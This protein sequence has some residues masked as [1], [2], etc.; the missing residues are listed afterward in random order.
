MMVLEK[1]GLIYQPHTSAGRVPTEAGYRAFVD[2]LTDLRPLPAPQIRA[3]EEFLA[4]ATDFEEVIARTVRLL[5]QLTRGAAVA[6][7]PLLPAPLLRRVEVVGLGPNRLV[8]VVITEGGQVFE[9]RLETREGTAEEALTEIRERLNLRLEGLSAERIRVET[10]NLIAEFRPENRNLAMQV[11]AAVA[12]MLRSPSQSRMVVAG[13][14]NI[15]RFGA[16][17]ADVSAVL[18][19][20]EQQ[21]ALLRLFSEAHPDRVRVSIGAENL[22]EDL[23]ETSVVSGAYQIGEDGSSHVGVIGPTRMDYPRSLIAVEA[24]SRYLS[25]LMLEGRQ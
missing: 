4:G 25:H 8:A 21:V 2:E 24:V 22:D 1:E 12:E 23:E 10:E 16:D 6:Q 17:F 7:Y 18:D 9:R 19:A 20:L 15:A 13:L 11:I 5:A 3:V 14:S